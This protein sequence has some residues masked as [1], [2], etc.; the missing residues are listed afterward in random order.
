[1]SWLD[2]HTV[3]LKH[4]VRVAMAATTSY[5]LAAAFHL[6]QGFWA[7]ITAVVVVQTSI[8]GTLAV[9][10]DRLL[11]T[12]VGALVG[13]LAAW[14][15]PQTPWGEAA[16]L[17]LSVGVTGL[18]ASL[19]PSLRIAPVTTVIMIVGS[20]VG[21][22]GFAVT[23]GL[24]VAEIALGSV[25]GVL[26]ALFV[27]PARASDAVSANV[28]IALDQLSRLLILYAQRLDGADDE[29]AIAP[30]H[31]QLRSRL[32]TIET[33]VAEASREH[34]ARLSATRVADAIP[35]TLWRLRNDAVMIGRATAHRWAGPA[36][37]RLG[38]PA[39]ALLRAQAE[40]IGAIRSAI[41]TGA[42]TPRPALEERF[43]AF[44]EAFQQLEA[45]TS[46][47]ALGT[48]ALGFEHLE[49]IFGLAFALEAFNTNTADLA[50]R[51]AE[52]ADSRS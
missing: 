35:R 52:F 49:Q 27:F 8:G 11:G 15:R 10:R 38:P 25:I 3:D 45:E 40:Q 19:W 28:Q 20:A 37:E 30:L 33:Q 13:A 26:I 44:R 22:A 46:P 6:P 14:L 43:A 32:G 34:A 42:P 51:I 16:A 47:A 41:A 9:S 17:A 48:G 36:A 21:S 1:M 50:E 39:A 23:A 24:R 18:A 7:V 4:A 29:V 5:A 12:S 31:A 2:R